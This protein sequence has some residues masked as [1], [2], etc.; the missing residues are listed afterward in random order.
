M[1][2]SLVVT[3]E[4]GVEPISTAEAKDHLRVTGTAQDSLIDG[5]VKAARTACE[6]FTRRALITQ[7]LRYGLDAFPRP[8]EERLWEGVRD[9]AD[10]ARVE[11]FVELPRPPLQ[12]V[13]SVVTYDDNDSATTFAASNYFTDTSS[14]PGRVILRTGATWPTALRVG[15]AIEIAYTAGYGDY[16]SDVPQAL[17]QGMYLMIAHFFENREAV[18]VGAAAAK[19]PEG[20][21]DLWRPYRVLTL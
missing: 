7:G 12:S 13:T 19:L 6:T 2:R 9:G 14:D 20:V 8:H 15:R 16:G 17:L 4:P 3:S 18:V 11:R 10:V 21:A 1:A 5:H